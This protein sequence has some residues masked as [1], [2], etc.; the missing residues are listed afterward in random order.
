[1]GLEKQRSKIFINMSIVEEAPIENSS[2]VKRFTEIKRLEDQIKDIV[3][4]EMP[5]ADGDEKL[6]AELKQQTD[7]LSMELEELKSGTST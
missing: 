3:E 2:E 5:A 6:I 7:I 4:H 1:M